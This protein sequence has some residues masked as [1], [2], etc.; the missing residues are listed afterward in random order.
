MFERLYTYYWNDSARY[1]KQT[2]IALYNKGFAL[3]VF[4]ISYQ[5]FG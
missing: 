1:E 5:Q 2:D 3:I 4:V